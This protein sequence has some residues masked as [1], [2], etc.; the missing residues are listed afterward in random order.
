MAIAIDWND[1]IG[2]VKSYY[3]TGGNLYSMAFISSTPILFYNK[4]LFRKA[5]LDPDKPPVATWAGCKEFWRTLLAAAGPHIPESAATNPNIYN[6]RNR[7][8]PEAP[9]DAEQ[10]TINAHLEQFEVELLAQP[11]FQV[12]AG[13]LRGQ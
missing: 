2:P 6:Y 12:E 5:G 9:S 4:D 3:S 1:L 7:Q 13:R 11:G 10:N 8:N